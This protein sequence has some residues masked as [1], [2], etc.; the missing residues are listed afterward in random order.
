MFGISFS[1]SLHACHVSLQSYWGCIASNG[2]TA[3]SKCWQQI[4]SCE[5]VTEVSQ[6]HFWELVPGHA[7]G[8][9]SLLVKKQMDDRPVLEIVHNLFH[10]L[11]TQQLTVQTGN[12]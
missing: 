1:S 5:D 11:G 9:I 6:A 3:L 4:T 7:I 2:T 12:E 10:N 8:S